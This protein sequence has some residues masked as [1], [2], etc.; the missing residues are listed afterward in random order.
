MFVTQD[1]GRTI[2]LHEAIRIAPL[3]SPG[4][5]SEMAPQLRPM[6]GWY[7]APSVVQEVVAETFMQAW[8]RWDVVPAPRIT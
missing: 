1:A 8:R 2:P 7:V 5:G 6:Q 4:L 3:N